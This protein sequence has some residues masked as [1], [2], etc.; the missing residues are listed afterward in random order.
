MK[1]TSF[2][3]VNVSFNIEHPL[4]FQRLSVQE[5]EEEEYELYRKKKNTCSRSRFLFNVVTNL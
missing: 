4:Y 5:E 3:K 2:F 1:K